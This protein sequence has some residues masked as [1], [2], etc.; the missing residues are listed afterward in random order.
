[1]NPLSTFV[2]NPR[3]PSFP[4]PGIVPSKNSAFRLVK[5]LPEPKMEKPITTPPTNPH[6]FAWRTY[7][8]SHI[9]Q[10]LRTDLQ[11]RN[12]LLAGLQRMDSKLSTYKV[13]NSVAK[14][15]DYM[16]LLEQKKILEK[17]MKDL[18]HKFEIHRDYQLYTKFKH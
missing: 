9:R 6:G 7:T 2:N 10:S 11:K 16:F 17:N 4:M 18:D 13:L 12:M 1:M 15:K 3:L 14:Y 8:E 5:P